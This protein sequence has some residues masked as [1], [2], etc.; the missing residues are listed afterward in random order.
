[1]QG[2]M[3][4]GQPVRAL[5]R[6]AE[7]ESILRE[8]LRRDGYSK[9]Q[10][11]F[12]ISDILDPEG[13]YEA[14]DGIR[15]VYH[16][17]GLVSFRKKDRDLLMNV[18]TKGTANLVNQAIAQ[19]IH[20]FIH[21]SS[22]A[23]LGVPKSPADVNET[24]VFEN[25]TGVSAYAL[26]KHLA[27]RE[28]WRGIEEGLNAVIVNPSI[29]LGRADWAKS[30]MKLFQRVSEGMTYYSP[31]STGFVDVRDLVKTMIFLAESEYHSDLFV[32]NGVNI[33][34]KDLFDKISREIGVK[35]PKKLAPRWIAEIMWRLEY[36]TY[37]ITGREA[38]L[39]KETVETAFRKRSYDSR[40]ISDISGIT[41][42]S[43]EETIQ[44]V[45]EGKRASGGF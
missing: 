26:S 19:N 31:G 35:G 13:L 25:T 30:S 4:R 2:L 5:I 10:P 43:I 8:R 20:K 36:L 32:I 41:F 6:K 16:C 24:F 17:A 9:A 39:T 21:V 40:K 1:M 12:F 38:L 18:N 29:I 33:S 11:E 3:E 7:D 22:V 45:V 23:A 15:H 37:L 28:I 44:W 27:E 34:Y 42:R 14:C